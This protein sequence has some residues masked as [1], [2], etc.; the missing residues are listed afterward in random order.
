ML[1]RSNSFLI[2]HPEPLL[3]LLGLLLPFEGA[4][5]I[6][7]LPLVDLTSQNKVLQPNPSA[8]GMEQDSR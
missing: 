5:R 3:G 6:K 1:L 8:I 2:I 7:L 4:K